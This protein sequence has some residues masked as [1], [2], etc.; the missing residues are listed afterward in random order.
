MGQQDKLNVSTNPLEKALKLSVDSHI[1][2]VVMFSINYVSVNPMFRY[3]W[4]KC[5]ACP[6]RTPAHHSASPQGP[7]SRR[8]APQP[9]VE[10]CAAAVASPMPWTSP[11]WS[12]CGHA[13]TA[14][15]PR[16][17]S[18]QLPWREG[19]VEEPC[20]SSTCQAEPRPRPCPNAASASGPWRPWPCCGR[21]WQ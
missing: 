4:C 9:Q 11:A 7:T 12:S 21:H 8:R 10:R 16:H 13:Q 20:S 14:A 15:T 18:V 1:S 6:H 5:I 2:N 19:H 3:R 17:T